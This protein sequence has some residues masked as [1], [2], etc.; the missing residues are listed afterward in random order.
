[1]WAFTMWMSRFWMSIRMG[2]RAWVRPI[3]M[4]CS[5]AVDGGAAARGA[6]FTGY[7]PDNQAEA[8]RLLMEQMEQMEHM[9][10]RYA[11][12]VVA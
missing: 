2:V 7:P 8:I 9:A 5:V 11:E 10:P 6:K 1:M 12:D 4:W 3:P